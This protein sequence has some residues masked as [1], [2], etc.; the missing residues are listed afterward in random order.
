MPASAP[1]IGRRPARAGLLRLYL[2]ALEIQERAT[3]SH[4]P[5]SKLEA[6]L[7][8][9]IV[10]DGFQEV[11]LQLSEACQ[12]L[13]LRHPGAQALCPSQAHPLD[14][15]GPGD[16]L[17][18]T[19]LKQHYP[20]TLLTPMKFLRRN[21]ASINE[22]LA[23]AEELQNPACPP[24]SLPPLARPASLPLL[25]LLRQ[26][27]TPNSMVFRHALRLSLG[28]VVGYGILQAFSLDKGYWILLTVLFVCQ[29]ATAPPGAGWC[30][31]CSVP[32]PAS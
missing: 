26:H 24:T 6:E 10:L 21:L 11:F 8:Q 20:K 27:L 13:G 12:R 4:Y 14:P 16:Q 1:A 18:F 28:L 5:Y 2:L 15:G 32:S 7:K 19:R 30:S 9:G 17:E 22:L 25:T 23:S 29:P 31:G 3:S